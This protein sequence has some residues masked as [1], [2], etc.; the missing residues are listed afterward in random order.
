MAAHEPDDVLDKALAWSDEGRRVAVATVVETWGSSP[1][2]RGSQLV[3]RDDGLFVGSVSGGCVEGKVV[4]GAIAA[5]ADREHR[6][7]ELG[8][9]NDEAWEVGLACGGTV[10]ILV[11]PVAGAGGKGPLGRE[12]LAR[13]AQARAARQAIVLLT[14]LD[15][16]AVRTWM[17]EDPALSGDV[18]TAAARALA[19]DDATL[20][21]DGAVFVQAI[22]P[23]LRLVIVGAV[24]IAEP[25]ARI[26]AQLGYDVTLVDPREAFARAERWPGLTVLTDWPDEVLAQAGVD[27]R[28]AIVA[29]THDPKID[30]PALVA[31]LKSRAF[32]VG[33]LGSR[34]THEARL[35]RLA[36]QGFDEASLARIHGPVGLRIGA[37]TPGE[38][39]LSI[40]AQMTEALRKAPAGAPAT[41]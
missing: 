24:H 27:H 2:P 1:R 23:P 10:R 3:V 20:A 39:A 41:A 12:T 4:E 21:S 6:L 26:A 33:A 36:E 16:S 14:P 35:V 5:M 7:L 15:G 37:R 34:K 18:A 40:A 9:S 22:N 13:I 8:V 28:T 30:D 25:L 19:T 17:P 31:A 11:E 32:Y 38:I 29:L